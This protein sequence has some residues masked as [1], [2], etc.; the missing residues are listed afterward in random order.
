M[1]V[2]SRRTA[3][4]MMVCPRVEN[5]SIAN[6]CV[7]GRIIDEVS[8][9]EEERVAREFLKSTRAHRDIIMSSGEL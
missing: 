4:E 2:A 1:L 7:V 6:I 3:K 9:D 8:S 5:T